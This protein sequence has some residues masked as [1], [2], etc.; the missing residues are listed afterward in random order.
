MR[1][2]KIAINNYRNLHSVTISFDDSCNF[3]VGENNIGKSNI[4]NLLNI[5]FTRRGF[6]YDD[7]TDPTLPI[8][9]DFN[10][11][12]SDNEIGHFE[13]LFDV[14]D[15]S[16]INVRCKQVSPEDNLEFCHFE[17][18]TYI[19]P[20][21]IK[22]LNYIY[23]DSLRN[24]ISEISFERSRGVGKFLARMI[25]DYLAD[26]E[27]ATEV[28][29]DGDFCNSLLESINSKLSRVKSFNDYA[30]HAVVAGDV[31]ALMPRVITLK[32]GDGGELSKC[33][34]GVQ[35]LLLV[36]L[37][38]LDKLQ[39][40]Y[41]Q[42]G[43]AGIF[44][45]EE[46]EERSISVVLGLDEPE[47][48]LHPYMQRSLIKY[49][50]GVI[51]NQDENFKNLIK[52]LFN[53]DKL[54]GQIILVTHSPSIIFND[55]RQIIRLYRNEGKTRI[56]SG[57]ELKLDE[58]LEKHLV[59]HFPFIKESFF[60]RCAIFVEGDSELS[61]FP[62][63]ANRR[64]IDLDDLG[65]CVIEAGG[66]SV[67]Q[68]IQLADK[69][70]IPCVGV[71]DADDDFSPTGIPNL[72]KTNER[73]FE[74]EL[75]KIVDMGKESVLREIL[76]NYDSMGAE[77]VLDAKALNKRAYKKYRYLNTETKSDVKLSD[78]DIEDK[79]LLKAYYVTWFGINKSYPLGRLIGM[80]LSEDLIPQIYKDIID[81][82][83]NHC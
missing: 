26:Q 64:N 19:A 49:L 29:I 75:M 12:L 7:F 15:H 11:K 73:D 66:D 33:G 8:V 16:S 50:N 44:V 13:D 79:E 10:L 62:L 42:R 41:D 68:L 2:K 20:S 53:I 48:H 18:G 43:E 80:T 76:L 25:K 31:S 52:E 57:C 38:F 40:I 5:L 6:S 21:L 14:E 72:F 32:D 51:N 67:L 36:M 17:T 78:I 1:I 82:A 35:F 27:I 46:T 81:Y 60:A 45:N 58:Q 63:F 55:Y 59:L 22:C 24:P 39:Y 4:L 71:I 61:S 77:R 56:V 28:L 70:C 30:V 74:A 9:I 83:K 47:I 23:Y 3:I 69:F 54:D 65:I 34:Y 37:S